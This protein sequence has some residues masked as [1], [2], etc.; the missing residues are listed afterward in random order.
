GLGL[1][2]ASALVITGCA[3]N[4]EP[5]TPSDDGGDKPAA[6][7]LTFKLGSLLP[8]TGSLAFLGA[9]MLAGV[10]LAVSQVNEADAGITIDLSS[11]DEGDTDTKAY[12][13][14]IETL[15]SEGI[16]ALVG[17]ASSSVTKLIIDGNIGAGIVTVSP[18]N[19]SADF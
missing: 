3:G 15:K 6:A 10:E 13:T 5:E 2:S 4:A 17:A 12:E 19:T 7:D 1:L 9:P 16:T 14:S 8:E 11:A 18:S